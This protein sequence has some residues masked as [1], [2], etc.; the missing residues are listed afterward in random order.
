MNRIATVLG[1]LAVAF[2]TSVARADDTSVKLDVIAGKK[3]TFIDVRLPPGERTPRPVVLICHGWAAGASKFERL[4]E[5]LAS[6]GFVAV[7]FQQ[8]NNWSNDTASWSSQLGDCLDSLEFFARDPHGPLGGWLDTSRVALLGHS[9][10]G[11]ASI[12]RAAEDP[13]VK[14]VVALAPVNQKNRAKLLEHAAALRAPLL[15]IAGTSD[16]LATTGTYTR[17]IYERAVNASA[18]DY[19]EVKGGDHDFYAGK[20]DKAIVARDRATAWL[21]RFIGPAVAGKSVGFTGAL[22]K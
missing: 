5:H 6:R 9:F 16:W 14:C 7:L 4:A 22:A 20:S 17:P 13:R 3:K 1:A 2:A 11:A 12:W 15:V 8:P 19:L 21:E 18:R 10:G